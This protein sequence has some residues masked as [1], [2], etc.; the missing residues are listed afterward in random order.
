MSSIWT[1]C[2]TLKPNDTIES[3]INQGTLV[4]GFVGLAECLKALVGSHHGESVEAQELGLKIIQCIR[5]GADALSIEYQHNYGVLATPAESLAGRFATL[6]KKEFG[7]IEGVTDRDY[8]TNSN[9]IPV[10]FKCTAQHKAQIEAPYHELTKAGHIF[11][12]ELDGDATHNIESIMAVVDLI[13]QN[14]IGY[15]S[16]NHNRSRCLQ[17]GYESAEKDLYFCPRCGGDEIDCLQRITGYLVG[18]T[19]RWNKAKYSE[20]KDR[21]QHE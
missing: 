1:G 14:N 19:N 3:V 11:Y 21:V 18:T 5:D 2:E 13:D 17:C 4:I 12:V 8:Y 9:H 6:D 10:Y 16:I 15:G 7:I 20:L